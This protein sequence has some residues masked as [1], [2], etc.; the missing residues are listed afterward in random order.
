MYA[1]GSVHRE[2][3]LIIVQQD[4]IVFSL[5]HFCRQL[6]MFLVLTPIIRSAYNVI[7][8]FN[9][10]L[11]VHFSIFILVINQIDA[12]NLFYNKFLSCLYVFRAPCAHHQEVKIVLY[13]IWYR[14][15]CRWPSGEQVER[16]PLSR[17]PDGHLQ[18]VT[19]PD[20]L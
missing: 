13:S 7:T 16:G 5:L 20:A 9:V 1:H 18:S 2:S 8:N 12:K 19:I 6:Y 14:H 4:A 17:A 15:T 10:L 3:D 11:T